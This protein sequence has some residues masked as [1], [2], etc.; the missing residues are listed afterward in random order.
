MDG[1]FVI[2]LALVLTLALFVAIFFM[3]KQFAESNKKLFDFLKENHD[4]TRLKIESDTKQQNQKATI[5]LRLQAY[6]RMVLFLERINPPN[7]LIRI[8]PGSRHTNDLQ[9]ALLKTIREEYEHNLS[10]QLFIT[11]SSWDLI[12]NAREEVVKS[13]NIAASRVKADD[14]ASI[15]AQEILKQWFSNAVDPVEKA[16][17]SLKKDLKNSF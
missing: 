7:L 8:S 11:G 4:I 10:Q 14:L 5:G 13:V 17:N 12:K 2:I 6:E 3:L 1:Q 16:I 9:S 15:Y